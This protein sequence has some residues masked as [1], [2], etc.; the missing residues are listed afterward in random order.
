MSWDSGPWISGPWISE[1]SQGLWFS[2]NGKESDLG[3]LG[4][5]RPEII[6]RSLNLRVIEFE[7]D[8]WLLGIFQAGFGISGVLER[9]RS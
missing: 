5:T 1:R 2:G 6:P 3:F 8:A 4:I 9:V 7:I